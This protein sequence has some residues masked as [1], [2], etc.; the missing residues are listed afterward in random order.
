MTQKK[1]MI[2]KSTPGN[3]FIRRKRSHAVAANTA[4]R[5]ATAFQA[6]RGVRGSGSL[7]WVR[8]A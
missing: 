8:V 4:N 6:W 7:A 5:R 3:H 2:S 1:P